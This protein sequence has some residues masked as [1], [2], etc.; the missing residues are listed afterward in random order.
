MKYI[1]IALVL[2]THFL[3]NITAGPSRASPGKGKASKARKEKKI[4]LNHA[5]YLQLLRLPSIGPKRA[6]AIIRLRKRKPFRRISQ[7]VKI[8]GIGWRTYRRLRPLI[9]VRRPYRK[10]PARKPKLK[11]R[12][13]TTKK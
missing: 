6:R 8:R 12:K 4:D 2:S 5:G 10:K 9:T 11:R 13:K 3:L 1:L 7:I